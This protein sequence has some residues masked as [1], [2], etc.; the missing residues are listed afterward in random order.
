MEEIQC[1]TF[2]LILHD[3]TDKG[4]ASKLN[5]QQMNVM[6]IAMSELFPITVVVVL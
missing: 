3:R 6:P 2:T 1:L 5:G 4:Y